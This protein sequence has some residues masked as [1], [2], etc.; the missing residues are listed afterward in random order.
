MW[1]LSAPPQ[2]YWDETYY[3][4]DA[5][6][7]LG[8]GYLAGH[9]DDPSYKLAGEITW[10]HPP[11]GKWMIALGVG[12]I[13]LRPIGWR[14][15]SALFGTAGVLLVYLL[16]LALWGSVWWAGLAGLL[17]SLDGLHIVQSRIAMLDIF[18]STFVLAAVY[19]MVLDRRESRRLAGSPRGPRTWVER[20][21]GTR[22]RLGSGLALGAAVATKW[23]G[24]FALILVVALCAQALPGEERRLRT[25]VASF[26]VIPLLVYLAAYATW[27]AQNGLDVPRFLALHWR[28]LLHQ[29]HHGTAQPENSSPLSW[30]FLAHPIRYDPPPG[31][32]ATGGGQIWLIGNP[33]LWWGFLLALPVLVVKAARR[34][35]KEIVILGAYLAMF[36]PWVF[37]GRTQFLFYMLPA[38]PFMCLGMV[39]GLRVLPPRTGARA[40]IVFAIVFVLTAAAYLP[41]WLG[42]G[43]RWIRL[44]LLS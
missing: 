35:W 1:G 27:F 2:P 11:M 26:V 42:L 16:A 22:Y 3:V 25:M 28:M 5:Y 14:L 13:G 43:I 18:L 10:V 12:P 39:A 41:A 40:A 23:S 19:L 30:P 20:T 24:A 15:P 37:L 21:F 7:Y 4:P 17:L 34:R 29:L 31:F 33:A 8:G 32:P 9:P 38:V 6:D 44:P 36:L